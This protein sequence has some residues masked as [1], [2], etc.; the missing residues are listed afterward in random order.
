MI[1]MK[2]LHLINWHNFQDDI[3]DFKN[4]TYL[5][6]VNAVGKTTIMDAVR[7]CLTTNKD[8]NTAGNK[9]SGRTLLGSVHQKQRAQESYLRP[10]HTVSYIGIEFLDEAIK[11]NFVIIARIE[12]E[13]PKQDLRG[14]YQDWYITKPGYSL[15]DI[16]FFTKKKD[17]KSPT[18]RDAFK[19]EN[20]GMDRASNQA[21]ARRRICRMLG[22]GEADS[23]IGKKFNEVFHM[24]TSLEDI[25][26][27]RE[28]IYTYILPE[29]EVNIEFLQKDMIELERLQEILQEAC[30]REELLKEINDKIKAAK[31]LLGKVKVNESL[32]AYANLQGNIEE[33]DEKKYLIEEWSTSLKI[34]DKKLLD[35]FESENKASALLYEAQRAAEENA[36]NK[37][38]LSLESENK[39]N[40]LENDKLI[41]EVSIFE[42][43][44]QKLFSLKDSLNKIGFAVKVADCIRDENATVDERIREIKNS[45]KLF[46]D[47]EEEIKN[48]DAKI[49][50]DI[51][52]L[53]D[54]SDIL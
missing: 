23:P 47:I 14:V 44:L 17:G 38:M 39:N 54:K 18:S 48:H 37:E 42:D 24:G 51:T 26:D 31:E 9:K 19:L 43:V 52:S 2:R 49:R 30:D 36:E 12:S 20:K 45:A 11:K 6:G 46:A 8:F 32:V 3:I 15:E 34:I 5:L 53:S 35:L 13:T 28:F 22:I 40:K 27:I 4:I 21:D 29:P 50:T 16:P 25:R 7:Y 10:G 41:L 33:T 1:R